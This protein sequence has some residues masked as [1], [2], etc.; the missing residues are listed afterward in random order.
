MFRYLYTEL[1]HISFTILGIQDIHFTFVFKF[2]FWRKD[3]LEVL[4][5]FEKIFTRIFSYIDDKSGYEFSFYV[6]IWCTINVKFL[7]AVRC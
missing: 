1:S 6:R 5:S 7:R 2:K 3:V 4:K